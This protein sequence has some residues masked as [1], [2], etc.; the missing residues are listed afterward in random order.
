MNLRSNSLLVKCFT[1][2]FI[3]Y[4][5]QDMVMGFLIASN[6]HSKGTGVTGAITNDYSTNAS[7]VANQLGISASQIM[8][9][10]GFGFTKYELI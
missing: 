5:P 1:S 10:R 2:A 3:Y 4:V 8:V 6:H 9:K 7:E